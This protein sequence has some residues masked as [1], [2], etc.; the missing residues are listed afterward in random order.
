LTTTSRKPV[1]ASHLDFSAITEVPGNR[2][3]A[4][5]L[6]MLYTRYCL[7]ARYSVGKDVLEV[8]CGPG[9]GLGY[10]A[11]GAR[12]VVGGDIDERNLGVA[13]QTYK[14]N[15]R[16]VVERFDAQAMPFPDRCFDLV[17]LFESIYYL[18]DADSFFREA[19]RVLRSDGVLLI[20]SVHS[21]WPGFHP[22][23][24][25]QRYY[26][27]YEL[28]ELLAR[29]G[30]HSTLYAGFPEKTSGLV[31][32]TVKFVRHMAVRLHLI[33]RTMKGK[34]WLKRVFYGKLTPIPREV[35]EA[36]ARLEPL[37]E[38][39]KIPSAKEYRMIYAIGHKS[40]NSA[41]I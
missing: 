6:A 12:R 31:S 9:I 5:Q 18:A 24:Y 3:S 13:K 22:S 28:A 29:H 27:H 39:S 36:M 33:P 11:R 17:I 21:S 10:L 1:L 30:F 7:A 19:H 14:G 35:A 34:E 20:S 2:A 4:D 16:I 37:V 41:T 38:I 23:P 15:P 40:L 32:R 8:A 26:N 25:S